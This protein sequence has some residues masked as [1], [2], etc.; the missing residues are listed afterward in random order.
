MGEVLLSI[1][2]C[3]VTERVQDTRFLLRLLNILEKQITEKYESEVEILVY[4]D[5]KQ[6]SIGKKRDLLLQQ[7][8]GKFLC[9][10]DDDDIVPEYYIER[11]VNII[12]TNT[13]IDFI[14]WKLCYIHNGVVASKP[15]I[16][17]I[18]FNKWSEDQHGYY[19]HMSHINPVL[20][21]KAIQVQ[22]D[23]INF[24][25]DH[26]WAN[27]VYKLLTKEYF[28]DDF[29]YYYLYFTQ[30]SLSSNINNCKNY[31]PSDRSVTDILDPYEKKN[32]I[33]VTYLHQ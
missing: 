17:S 7:A 27:E 8:K 3:T 29:M 26:K 21:T 22:F 2:I 13:D 31:T 6:I 32:Y 14:G 10:I 5:N 28:I 15:A 24:G 23:N 33:K 18:R 9:F 25:E 11:I 1:L 20:R 16:H 19:R 12:K 4:C 30:M